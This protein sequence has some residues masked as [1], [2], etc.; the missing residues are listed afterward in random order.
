M[1]KKGFQVKKRQR[2]LY[3]GIFAG[4]L[5]AIIVMLVAKI[6]C[7][8]FPVLVLEYK[9]VSLF[10][11]WTSRNMLLFY[12]HSF[13]QGVLFAHLWAIIKDVI[14]PKELINRGMGFGVA[15]W[16]VATVPYMVMIYASFAVSGLLIV[17][18]TVAELCA[19][20]VAGI[21]YAQKIK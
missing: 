8:L 4:L 10:A 2:I 20:M 11:P 21:I 1:N 12:F 3:V 16:L 19:L 5:M 14:K 15:M 17:S 7:Y 13:L 6:F 18:W 9:N